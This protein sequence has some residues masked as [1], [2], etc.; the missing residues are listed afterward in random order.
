MVVKKKIKKKNKL[1]YFSTF[2]KSCL[3]E[4]QQQ[5]TREGEKKKNQ[6][7]ALQ[8]VLCAKKVKDSSSYTDIQAQQFYT[9]RELW[10]KHIYISQIMCVCS[11]GSD[12]SRDRVYH[13]SK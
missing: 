3:R 4:K 1:T 6:S 7:K 12:D 10:V 11:V 9:K 8:S 5:Y 13:H 2:F